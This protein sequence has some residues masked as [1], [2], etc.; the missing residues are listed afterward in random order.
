M[1]NKQRD[2]SKER[3]WRRMV[4]QWRQSKLTIREFCGANGLSEPSFYGWRR[5]IAARD[6]ESSTT[7]AG[8][9]RREPGDGPCRNVPAFVPV[10]V[11][12]VNAANGATAALP[13][14]IVLRNQRVVRVA[15]GFDAATLRQLLTVMEEQ[16]C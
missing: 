6:H 3:F 10:Q 8:R 16:S 14:E 11:V 15:P 12:E 4:R 5:V 13:L 9:A 2:K 7:M 1:A